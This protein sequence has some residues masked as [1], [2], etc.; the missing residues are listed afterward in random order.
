MEL[1]IS[2]RVKEC[3]LRIH[4]LVVELNDYTALISCIRVLAAVGANPDKFK[5]TKQ[6]DINKLS[7]R[8]RNICAKHEIL[9][10]EYIEWG[11]IELN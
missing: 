6:E 9:L 1:N 10:P 7:D 3:Q 5:N 11:A 4:D 8:V 2:D